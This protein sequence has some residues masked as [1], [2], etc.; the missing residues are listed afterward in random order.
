MN[1]K[2]KYQV[3]NPK[4]IINYPISTRNNKVKV[5][6]VTKPQSV[7][8]TETYNGPVFHAGGKSEANLP[9]FL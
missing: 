1:Y 8:A 4:R 7:R 9:T 5:H 2:G 3:F 6:D